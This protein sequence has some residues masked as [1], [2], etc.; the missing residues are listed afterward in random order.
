MRTPEE[1]IEHLRAGLHALEADWDRCDAQGG[2]AAIR[3]L[4]ALN[5]QME[6]IRREIADVQRGPHRTGV[7]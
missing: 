5:L 4:K 1:R 6:Q 7:L 3:N 2:S